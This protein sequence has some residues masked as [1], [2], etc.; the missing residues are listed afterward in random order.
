MSDLAGLSLVSM[1][2]WGF[3]SLTF[4]FVIGIIQISCILCVCAPSF[5]VLNE[6]RRLRQQ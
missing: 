6:R 5:P 1:L 2:N 4:G 3:D